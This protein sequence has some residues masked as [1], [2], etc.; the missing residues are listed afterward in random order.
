MSSLSWPPWGRCRAWASRRCSSA[1]ASRERT[2]GL[3][4]AALGVEDSNPR[5]RHLYKRLGYQAVGRQHAS[6]ETE[7][8]TGELRVYETT[9]TILR[10]RL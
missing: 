5:A 4:F 7:D 6:W 8:D 1:P 2:R 10:K 3:A 9:L